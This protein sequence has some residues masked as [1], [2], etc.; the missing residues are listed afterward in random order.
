MGTLFR[1]ITGVCL[2][3][4]TSVAAVGCYQDGSSSVTALPSASGGDTQGN[5]QGCISQFD[6]NRDY[7]PEKTQFGAAS[8]I[9]VEYHKSYKVVTV[10]QTAPGASAERYVLVQCGAP[11]P[12]LEGDLAKAVKVQIPVKKIAASSTTQV[13]VLEMLG[14]TERVVGVA[15]PQYLYDGPIRDAHAAGKIK[16]YANEDGTV[17]IEQALALAP[18]L[19]LSGGFED[20]SYAKLRG[21]KIPVVADAS[22]LDATPLGRTEWL[23]YPALFLNLEAKA[24]E[25]F[26]KIESDYKA[27]AAKVAGASNRPSV[28]VGQN[29]AGVWRV[30]GGDS[31]LAALIKDAGG[32]YVFASKP[33]SESA[34][35]SMETVLADAAKAKFWLNGQPFGAKWKTV[36][37]VVAADPRN[38]SL[39]AVKLGNVWDPTLRVNEAGGNDYWQQGAVR[40]DLVLADLVAIFHPDLAASRTFVF[41]QKVQ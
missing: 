10:D 15:T 19:F 21:A 30:P 29:N 14:A 38:E 22:W 4:A 12:T 23:K 3:I 41:Y 31:Y 11:E 39:E 9:K 8:G 13:P 35:V 32:D 18:D 28:L 16:G 26:G 27:V 34:E 5:Q 37:D 17:N 6:A 24:N 20:P 2:A 25:L 33:G 36:A 1:R 7:F 40:P